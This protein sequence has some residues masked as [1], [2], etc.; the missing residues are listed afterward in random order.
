MALLPEPP[1]SSRTS[2]TPACQ[3]NFTAT[4]TVTPTITVNCTPTDLALGTGPPQTT[5]G[6]CSTQVNPSGGTFSWSVNKST[7]TL[8]SASGASISYFSNSPSS[9]Q[10]DTTISVSYTMNSQSATAQSSRITTHNPTSLAVLSDTTNPTVTACS[11]P[12]LANPGD[13]TCNAST[14]TC[15]YSSY[16]RTCEY[17]VVDQLNQQFA[18]VGISDANVVESLPVS[19]S[20]P[21]LTFSPHNAPTSTFFDDFTLCHTCCLPNG[22]G[23]TLQSAPTQ[24]ILVNGTQVWSEAINW[25]CSNVSLTP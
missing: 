8:S 2:S 16:R 11:V 15:S 19:T 5:G 21:N 1:T 10:G 13:G 12:C 9:S 7:V 4:A 14:S 17:S 6:S 23:C 3:Y 22:P 20:C 24:V 18:N 25:T